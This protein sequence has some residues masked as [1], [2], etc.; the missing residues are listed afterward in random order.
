MHCLLCLLYNIINENAIRHQ[1][2]TFHPCSVTNDVRLH[3]IQK[4]LSSIE[5]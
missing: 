5:C 3:T 2:K 1:N 4:R